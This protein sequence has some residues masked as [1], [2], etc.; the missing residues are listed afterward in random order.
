MEERWYDDAFVEGDR[1]LLSAHEPAAEVERDHGDGQCSCCR[2]EFCGALAVGRHGLEDLV[3][4]EPGE[5]DS[6]CT[7][8][9]AIVKAS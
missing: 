3:D 2:R 7:A 9:D 5:P 8:Y 6:D 1:L 4:E